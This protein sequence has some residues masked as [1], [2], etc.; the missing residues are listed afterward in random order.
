MS[1]RWRARSERVAGIR[2]KVLGGVPGAAGGGLAVG[3]R[4]GVAESFGDGLP[5]GIRVHYAKEIDDVLAV[6]LPDIVA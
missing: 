1:R 5:C 6:V 2:E 4:G 3:Q